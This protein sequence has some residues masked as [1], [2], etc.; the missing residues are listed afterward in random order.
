MTEV[1][2]NSK[3]LQ[4]SLLLIYGTAILDFLVGGDEVPS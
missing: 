3:K 4:R 1:L 2:I